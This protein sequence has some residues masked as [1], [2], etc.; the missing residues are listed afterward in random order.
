MKIHHFQQDFIF[1]QKTALAV[2][3]FDGV[4]LGHK[5]MLEKLLNF[6]SKHN[7]KPVVLSLYPHPKS[8]I[9][10][11]APA[12]LTT[13]RDKAELLEGLG[14]SDWVLL[15]FRAEIMKTSPVE[16]LEIL[17]KQLRVNYLISGSD[18]KFGYKG[19]GDKI[20][21]QE[22][23]IKH[24]FTY[25]ILENININN[26]RISSSKIRELLK[27]YNLELA[28]KLLGHNLS[29]TGKVIKGEQRGRLLNFPTA[30]LNVPENWAL[31][32]GVYAVKVGEKIAVA[33]LGSS[34]TF[35]VFKRKLE[36]HLLNTKQ[37]LYNKYIKVEFFKFLREIKK[38]DNAEELKQQINK[39]ILDSKE[40]FM[41]YDE[42]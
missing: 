16:F 20:Y 38:F 26:E 31:P 9:L 21:L 13:L 42:N 22:M 14:I 17:R 32:N 10:G 15:P 8:L 33:N 25:E 24:N 5:L 3:N 19:Q 30:N 7:L 37:D 6:S 41:N 1:K 34:P 39:D 35:K 18:F 2:G 27:N 11:K 36:V 40:F 12:V 23:A 28:N 4:H 29:F